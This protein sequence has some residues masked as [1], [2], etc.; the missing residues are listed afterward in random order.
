[1]ARDSVCPVVVAKIPSDVHL[2]SVLVPISAMAEIPAVVPLVMSLK[3]VSG[4]R[5]RFLRLMPHEASNGELEQRAEQLREA[6]PE[7][8]KESRCDATATESRVHRILEASANHDIVV[9]SASDQRGLR[10]VFFGSLAE[11]VAL[12]IDRPMLLVRGGMEW[13]ALT[14]WS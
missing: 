9:M 3:Q 12:R 5:I 7:S 14:G 1:V 10:R 4:S 13:R 6:L 2:K 8:L 11:D